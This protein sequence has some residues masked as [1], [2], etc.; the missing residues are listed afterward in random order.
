[1]DIIFYRNTAGEQTSKTKVLFELNLRYL[2]HFK[3]S[4][5]RSFQR[6]CSWTPPSVLLLPPDLLLQKQQLLRVGYLFN[7]QILP[8]MLKI[9]GRKNG[10]WIQS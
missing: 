9:G 2:S 1:M 4:V 7:S 10:S 3:C 6:P 5:V 8:L